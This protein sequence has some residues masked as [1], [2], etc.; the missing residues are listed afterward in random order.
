ML[1]RFI[2]RKVRSTSNTQSE[3]PFLIVYDVRDLGIIF[4]TK[5]GFSRRIL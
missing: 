1:Y 5:V 3:I 4:D 2:E